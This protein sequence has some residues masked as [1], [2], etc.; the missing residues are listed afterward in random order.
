MNQIENTLTSLEVA[1][2]VGR[3]HN[4][5]LKDIR[6]II[7][8]IGEVKNYQSYFLEDTYKNSQNREMPC[9]KLTKQGCELYGG[10]MSGAKG[11]HFAMNYI[12]RFNQ[13]EEYIKQEEAKL[14][15]DP[16]EILK[17]TF[18][19]QENTVKEVEMVKDRV[20]DLEENAPLSPGD[21]GFLGR[22]ITQRVNEIARSYGGVTKEQRSK[23][24]IDIN[25]GVKAVTG[26]QTRTQLRIKHYDIAL[27]FINDWEPSTATKM[28]IKQTA[29]DFGTA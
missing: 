11:T 19:A 20:T 6:N 1:E 3:D 14:P 18:Q 29:F 5:V 23:L 25:Q 2:M 21:Y 28:Q 24:Y 8:Q 12:E 7:E 27:A 16:M 17:L 9:F 26:T 15:T 13:M 22:R 10:R 4:N